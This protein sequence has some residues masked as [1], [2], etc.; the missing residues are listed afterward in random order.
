[1]FETLKILK[2]SYVDY[3]LENKREVRGVA[4]KKII[5]LITVLK[6]LKSYKIF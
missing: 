4:L 1:M 2:L 5:L 6:T 3:T